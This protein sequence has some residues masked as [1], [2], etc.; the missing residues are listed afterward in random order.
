MS[1]KEK[2][3]FN[4]KD[5]SKGISRKL[6]E[7]IN[8]NI[9]PGNQAM[10]SIVKINPHSEGTIHKHPQ[11]QWSLMISGNAIRIQDNE[12]I[13]VS[14]GDF[15]CTPGGIQHGVIGGIKGAVIFDF[16]APPREE[17]KKSGAGYAAK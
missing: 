14:E 13:R 8:A 6:T 11:E 3:F 1:Q 15:W 16:F 17:Y 4:I 7:G 5:L 10:V 2:N 9:F 12:K